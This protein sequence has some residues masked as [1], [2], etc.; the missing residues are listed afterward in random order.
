MGGFERFIF[1]KNAE[2]SSPGVMSVLLS[3]T[4]KTYFKVDIS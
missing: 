4:T 2:L 1:F 3:A